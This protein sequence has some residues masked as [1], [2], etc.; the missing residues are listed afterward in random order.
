MKLGHWAKQLWLS[1]RMRSSADYWEQRYSLGMDSGAGSYGELASYKAGILNAFVLAEGIHSVIEFGCGDGN[2]LA[3]AQYPR[4]LGLDVSRTA[5]GRCAQRFRGHSDKSFLWYDP[6]HSINLGA[7]LQADLILSLDVIYHLIEE[8]TYRDYLRSLFASAQRFVII[9]SSD[10]EV[11]HASRHVR[12]RKF[13]ADVAHDFPQFRLR[14]HI[15][16][17]HRNFTFADFHIYARTAQL[18]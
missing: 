12:H 13:T 15:H 8:Q 14:E 16:N 18:N 4:Y 3:L 2:Q 7:F 9:Y 17:P 5:I 6:A 10:S 1:M 11:P